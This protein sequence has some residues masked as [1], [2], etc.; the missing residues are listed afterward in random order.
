MDEQNTPDWYERR[1]ELEPGMI[2][3]TVDGIVK[4]DRQVP[5][6]GTKWE[7]ADWC[8]NHWTYEETTI[9]PGDL[10]GQPIE[11]TPSTINKADGEQ[12]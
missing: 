9:E 8:V 5:G 3:R 11:D 1:H 12:K 7:V 10:K 2:F 6:D 4:L